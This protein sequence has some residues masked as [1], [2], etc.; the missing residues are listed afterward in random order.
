MWSKGIDM[1][2]IT[3]ELTEERTKAISALLKERYNLDDLDTT[4]FIME[5]EKIFGISIPV[6]WED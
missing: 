5:L 1:K 4:E 6:E 2:T 3:L